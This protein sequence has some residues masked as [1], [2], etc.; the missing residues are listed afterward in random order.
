[1]GPRLPS[2][3]VLARDHGPQREATGDALPGDH[4]VGLHPPVL[5]GPHLAGPSHARLDLV[6]HE[7]DPVPLAQ[8]AEVGHPSIRRQHVSALAQ[9]GL[10][11]DGR[12]LRR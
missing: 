10:H 1:M 11:H 3:Q 5:D 8:L 2:H 12:H 4:D 9:D 7:Q 6:G